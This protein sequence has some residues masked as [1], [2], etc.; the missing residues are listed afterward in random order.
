MIY[1]LGVSPGLYQ[2]I[3]PT[4]ISGW[5]ES[6]LKSSLVIGNPYQEGFEEPINAKERRYALRLVKE[7]LH[8][9]T[10]RDAV[11]HAYR[12][13]CA[14]TGLPETQLLD[15]A[16]I[17]ADGDVALG[18]PV[19]PNGLALSKIHHAAFDAHLIGIDP[20]YRLHVSDR[21]LDKEDGPML[22]ALKQ[23]K[24]TPL[25]LPSRTIDHPDPE[26]LELRFETFR[27]AG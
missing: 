10:F 4:F 9:D 27:K 1:F 2:A 5:D 3:V 8:Q 24:G 13:R 6:T 19:V 7:R 14:I 18:Q 11:L 26:R 15:A 21:L 12:G 22:Q 16:H 20:D 25:H 17:I 23:L